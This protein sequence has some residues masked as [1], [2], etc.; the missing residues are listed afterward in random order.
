M[1]AS[2]MVLTAIGL[3]ALTFLSP[4]PNLLVVVQSS[5]SAGREAGIAAGAGVALGDAI[6][7]GLGLFGMTAAITSGGLLF[8]VIKVVGGVYLL[9]LAF[10]LMLRHESVQLDVVP[11]SRGLSLVQYF[12]RGVVTDLANPQTMLFFASV[13][14]VTLTPATPLAVKAVAWFGIVLTSFVWRVFLS[15]AF[16]V[17]SVRRVYARTMRLFELLAGGLLGAFG[18]RLLIEGVSGHR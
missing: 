9:W 15:C 7:A 4:G 18:A 6:Y 8:S 11:A 3:F 10:R 16:S 5:L 13:F 14:A 2:H 17:P 1:D 12:R